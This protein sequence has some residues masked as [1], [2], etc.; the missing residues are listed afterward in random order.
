M[1]YTDQAPVKV[2][3]VRSSAGELGLVEWIEP[4]DLDAVIGRKSFAPEKIAVAGVSKRGEI[5]CP[6]RGIDS[7]QGS[8]E[9]T[10]G[11]GE[12]DGDVEEEV[13]A[14]ALCGRVAELGH[15]AGCAFL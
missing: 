2:V 1:Q 12:P 3:S 6:A 8:L 10:D 7:E 14:P 9:C 13:G 15:A 4:I 11:D 5:L